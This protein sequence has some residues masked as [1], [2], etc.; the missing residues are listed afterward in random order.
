MRI[1]K[2]KKKKRREKEKKKLP[3][4]LQHQLSTIYPKMQSKKTPHAQ[5]VSTMFRLLFHSAVHDRNK[6]SLSWVEKKKKE[7][8]N[9]R[10]SRPLGQQQ[11]INEQIPENTVSTRIYGLF[12]TEIDSQFHVGTKPVVSEYCIEPPPR[13]PPC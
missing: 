4:L 11:K 10:Y 5:S 8:K 13:L 6:R 12:K 7:V 3:S 2:K 1:R 9:R